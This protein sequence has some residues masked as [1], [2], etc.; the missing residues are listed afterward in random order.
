MRLR[1]EVPG[2]GDAL[3]SGRSAAH[4][5]GAGGVSKSPATSTHPSGFE[6]FAVVTDV[7]L[8]AILLLPSFFFKRVAEGR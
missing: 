6:S 5:E 4:H 1:D 2:A 3:Q 7:S 8:E